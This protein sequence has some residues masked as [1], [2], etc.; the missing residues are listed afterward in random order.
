LM[1]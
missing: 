1:H